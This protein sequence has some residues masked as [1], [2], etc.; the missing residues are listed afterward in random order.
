MKILLTADLHIYNHGYDYR[1][2]VDGLQCLKWIYDEAISHGIKTVVFAGDFFHNRFII[3]TYASSQA[4]Q[5][6]YSA[7]EKGVES[8]FLLGNHDLYHDND[9]QDH[10]L[11]A[12]KE[13]A[14]VID[15]PRTIDIDGIPVD[16]LPYTP[17][18]KQHLDAFVNPSNVLITHLAILDALLNPLYDVISVEDDSKEK[19]HIKASDFLKWKKVWTGHYHYGQTLEGFVEYIGSPMW[20]TFGEAN[21][22]KHIA[23]FD[24]NSLNTEY[25]NNTISPKFYIINNEKQLDYLDYKDAYIRID[26]DVVN[27]FE[28]R[29]KLHK[30]GARMVR[31]NKIDNSNETNTNAMISVAGMYGNKTKLVEEYLKFIDTKQLNKEELLKLG[32]EIV[33]EQ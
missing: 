8:I 4:F 18:P 2:I 20:L 16:F 22:N 7:K 31:F 10:S 23:I 33:N 9:W 17:R 21:Q 27:K 5:I 25:I 32:L 11:Q 28:I 14:T 19:D 12:V 6:V 13:W 24:L 3:N 29:K 15:S 30:L 26:Y 1:R